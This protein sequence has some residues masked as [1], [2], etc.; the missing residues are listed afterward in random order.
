MEFMQSI[1]KWKTLI[2]LLTNGC[3][4]CLIYKLFKR[5]NIGCNETDINGKCVVVT[6]G[7]WTS[8]IISFDSVEHKTDI[9]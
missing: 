7:N 3:V 2:V 1:L 9:H 5:N 6:G 4:E 8:Q